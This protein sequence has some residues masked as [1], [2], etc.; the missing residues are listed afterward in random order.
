[1]SRGVLLIALLSCATA[2]QTT[3]QLANMSGERGLICQGVL[4]VSG[5]PLK[6]VAGDL[7]RSSAVVDLNGDGFDDLVVGAPLLPTAPASGVLD[8]AGHVYV[9]FGSAAK[10][11][12]GSSPDFSFGS[13]SQGQAVD[14][15]GDPGDHAGASVSAA[16]DVDGDGFDD[17]VIGAPSR[18][19]GGR[20]SAG[21][22]YLVL[23]RGDFAT[24]P[25]VLVLSALAGGNRAV[26][27]EGAHEFG[28]SGS[29]VSGG[30]DCN[31]DGFDD[32]VLG[33][34][35][36]S[37][38]GH[39]Q[40]GTATVFYGRAGL[41]ALNVLDLST[42]G[43]GQV[44][45]V[46]GGADFAFMGQA[47]AG[48]G[49]FDPVLP[50]TSNQVNLF[51]GDDVALGAPGT[52]NGASFFTGA[53]YVL[54]GV[55]SGVPAV[56]YTT[57]DFGNGPFKAGIVYTG[58]AAGDQLGSWLAPAGDLVAL[59]GE[60]FEDFLVTAPFND[61]LGKPDCGAV[62]VLV[63]RLVGQNPQGFNVSL[64]G[65]GL[66]NVLGIYIQGAVSAGGQS[67]VWAIKAGDWNGDNVP[68]VAVG[69]PNV[70]TLAG[71]VFQAAGVTRIL[72]GSKVLFAAGTVDL[73]NP[74]ASWDLMQLQG[75]A[76]GAHVGSGLAMGDFNGDGASDLSIG[77]SGAP[78]D[79]SPFDPTGLAHLKTGRAHVLYGPMTR[80][81]SVT[82]SSS[83]FGGP[84]VTLAAFSVPASGVSVKVDG[85]AATVV[86]VTPG[87]S[88]SIVIAPPAPTAFGALAD[89]SLDTPS[90]DIS[91]KDLLQYVPL[92]ITGG[93][94]PSSGSPGM[95]IAL[96]GQAF[97]TVPNTII[98]VGGFPATVT[99]VDGLAGTLSF[100]LPSGPTFGVPLDLK[101]TN[102]NGSKTLPG[103]IQYLPIS[104]QSITPNSA[105]QDSGVFSASAVPY[106]GEPPTP[107]QITVGSTIGPPPPDVLVEFGTAALGYRTAHVT[108]V[109]GNVISAE[110]PPFLLGPQTLVDVRVTYSGESGVL[111][112][113]FTYLKSDFKELN[114]Y[115]QAGY[116]AKP[117]R[118]L[119]AGQFTNG[120]AVLCQVD[121]IPPQTQ[122]AILFLGLGLKDPPPTIHG[123]P[124]PIDIGL[125][126]F[127]VFLP[128][129]STVSISKAM[130]TNID[131]SSDGASL[132][133]HILT[134]EKSGGV[135]KWGFSN[136]L[137]MT[138]DL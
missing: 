118:A 49:K 9:L 17:V 94:T 74:V 65:Q 5:P 44:T 87:D 105:Q 27:L 90:G 109:A 58:A 54:R 111:S 80:L 130:P 106:Q 136:I 42:Q 133:I 52:S 134:K 122:N 15:A 29:A 8:D 11:L 57:A 127:V 43:A 91:Y 7:G 32:V 96:T 24:L 124:F 82:P 67:G 70:A 37:T 126:F 89:I 55:A 34:P 110:V 39:S 138:V 132:Y 4:G 92:A 99:A 86:S 100:T 125:P 68:D 28:A 103:A 21:G 6:P 30:V 107:V 128:P 51:F 75:E 23:G 108:G 12:P 123:G 78:S 41:G 62:Y 63:G 56:S 40:N 64:L 16:G 31:H 102:A 47:V 46:H 14:L 18:T 72:D 22:A 61:G 35:L 10:G 117:P 66:P 79:P 38:N 2:A 69:F 98:T 88:G 131:P 83:W 45:V 101:V 116:G 113:G 25:K 121:Q 48:I 104:V 71:T 3:L 50:M 73:G 120:A 93:P 20:T 26:F 13:F 95:S 59:D 81:I 77:A 115:A 1:M 129:L 135:V 36:D 85:L 97:S 112:N 76:T 84:Q 114:Q 119:M 137:Q 33:A 53:V 19:V 60:G